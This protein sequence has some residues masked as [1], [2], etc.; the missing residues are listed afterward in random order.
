[1]WALPL[2]YITCMPSLRT[3]RAFKDL[4]VWSDGA[5]LYFPVYWEHTYEMM[6]ERIQMGAWGIKALE[7]DTGLDVV[8]L[9]GGM[10]EEGRVLRLSH[11]LADLTKAGMLSAS[12]E[13]IDYLYDNTA[14]AVAELYIQFREEGQLSYEHEEPERSLAEVKKFIADAASLQYLH[15]MLCD[16]RDEVKDDSGEREIVELWRE[17]DWEEWRAHLLSLIA[18]LASYLEESEKG[19]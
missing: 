18:Q 11:I 6:K 15:R 13:D 2:D 1:M 19:V 7:S 16:I 3:S 14:M 10:Q 9:V 12:F 8:D 4:G 5:G 17:A